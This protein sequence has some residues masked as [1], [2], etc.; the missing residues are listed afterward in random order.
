MLPIKAGHDLANLMS[1]KGISGSIS[2]MGK[3]KDVGDPAEM[4]QSEPE[5]GMSACAS[6]LADA[7]I[8]GD[9]ESAKKLIMELVDRIK[10]DDGEQDQEMEP[11]S[12]EEE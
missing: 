3:P 6:D 12:E 10:S 7:L 4:E 9:K 5:D 1:K 11:P 2:M 8:A